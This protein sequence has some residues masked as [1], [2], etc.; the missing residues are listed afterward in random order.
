MRK[1]SPLILIL[2]EAGVYRCDNCIILSA[3]LQSRVLKNPGFVSGYRFSD[4]TSPSKS[5]APF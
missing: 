1:H 4:I 3:A 5:D 2:G